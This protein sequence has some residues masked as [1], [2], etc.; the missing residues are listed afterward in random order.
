MHNIKF[1]ASSQLL[2]TNMIELIILSL[3][4]LVIIIFTIYLI[5]HELKEKMVTNKHDK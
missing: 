1:V 5:N 3:V 2:K 4:I